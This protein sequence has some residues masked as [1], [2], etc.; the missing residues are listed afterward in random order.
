ML[1][2]LPMGNERHWHRV[3]SEALALR[4][5]AESAE[6]SEGK[7]FEACCKFLASPASGGTFSF[8]G[9]KKRWKENP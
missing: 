5:L 8:R 9:K 2:A 1:E 6:W 3:F 7:L 4:A